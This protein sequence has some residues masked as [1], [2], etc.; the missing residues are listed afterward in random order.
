[1]THLNKNKFYYLGLE[2]EFARLVISIL[3]LIETGA[4]CDAELFVGFD[5]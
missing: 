3:Y 2:R 4:E 5:C 1:M